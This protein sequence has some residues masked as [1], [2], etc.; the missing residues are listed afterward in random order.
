MSALSKH[1]RVYMSPRTYIGPFG[2]ILPL[3]EGSE[4]DQIPRPP[5]EGRAALQL[6]Q[7]ALDFGSDTTLGFSDPTR[8]N[9]NFQ[10]RAHI[11]PDILSTRQHEP[12]S[13]LLPPVRQLLPLKIQPD[14]SSSPLP[15]QRHSRIQPESFAAPLSHHAAGLG[16]PSKYPLQALSAH[17]GTPSPQP[18]R[19]SSSAPLAV[20]QQYGSHFRHSPLPYGDASMHVANDHTQRVIHA[21]LPYQHVLPL[22]ESNSTNVS[23]IPRYEDHSTQQ[24]LPADRKNAWHP[25]ELGESIFSTSVSPSEIATQQTSSKEIKPTPKVVREETRPGQG[26]VWIYE[27]GSTCPKVVDGETVN[28]EWGVT[29]AGKPRKRLALACTACREKKIKCDPAQPQCAQCEKFGRVCKYATA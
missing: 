8:Y 18:N 17:E 4:P 10:R 7:P 23:T 26:A 27:D 20:D 12:N 5:D 28:A 24:C 11:G 13:D 6:P 3:S 29:K 19:Q 14:A 1:L 2:R 25:G 15:T 22:P 16:Q 21:R 9:T